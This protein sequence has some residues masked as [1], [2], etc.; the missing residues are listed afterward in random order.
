MFLTVTGDDLT[1]YHLTCRIGR[2]IRQ[3]TGKQGSCHA[4][5]HSMATLM[6]DGGADIRHIQEMLGQVGLQTTEIYTH[7][8]IRNLKAVHTATHPAAN[9]TPSRDRDAGEQDGPRR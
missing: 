6:L 9:N 5:R 3:A 4:P 7:V 2:Y 8:S 1:P